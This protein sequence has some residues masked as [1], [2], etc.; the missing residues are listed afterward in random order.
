MRRSALTEAGVAGSHDGLGAGGDVELGEDVGDMVAERLGAHAEP[1]RD[2]AV[3]EP[4]GHQVEDLGLACGE[5]GQMQRPARPTRCLRLG[6]TGV[7]GEKTV[8]LGEE[9]IERRLAAQQQMIP[10]LERDEAGIGRAGRQLAPSALHSAVRFTY[11][12]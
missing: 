7:G 12:S 3:V 2:L 10:A 11:H 4:P 5:I 9:L 6:G 1:R 8:Q